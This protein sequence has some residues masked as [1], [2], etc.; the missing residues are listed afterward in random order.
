VCRIA[1]RRVLALGLL[2]WA[3]AAADPI[4]PP[5][6]PSPPPFASAQDLEQAIENLHRL[7]WK[8]YGDLGQCDPAQRQSIEA[9]YRQLLPPASDARLKQLAEQARAQS[10]KNDQAGERQTLAQ[11]H[12]L[13]TLEASRWSMVELRIALAEVIAAHQDRM[14]R[15]AERLAA[16]R[17]RI[18]LELV[19][20][21]RANLDHAVSD[22]LAVSAPAA[23]AAALQRVL[24]DAQD[25]INVYNAQ[26]SFLAR[27]LSAQDHGPG[28]ELAAEDRNAPC[29]PPATKTSGQERPAVRIPGGDLEAF[30][31]PAVKRVSLEG[32]VIVQVWVSPT[33]CALKA[34]VVESSGVDELDEAA[35]QWAEQ[36]QFLPAESAQRP[37][38]A[39]TRMRVKFILAP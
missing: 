13:V 14:Q 35:I 16:G 7:N 37:T 9:L 24:T 22:A 38:A 10:A 31:P 26:R 3:L 28:T 12:E 4:A 21:A 23:Q 39:T 6:L 5:L 27:Q 20:D 25:L 33:G 1:A 32:S 34:A 18:P 15:L 8:A 30:Y 11:A 29:P 19:A 2:L 36:A 17:G